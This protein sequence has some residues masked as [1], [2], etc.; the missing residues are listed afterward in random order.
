MRDMLTTHQRAVLFGF[1][2]IGCALGIQAQSGRRSSSKPTTTTPSV[3]GPK[4][5]EAKSQKP[6]RLQ[7]LLIVE[8]PNPFNQV[9]YYLSD[10][11]VDECARRLEQAA[12]VLATASR[13]H[14]NRAQAAKAAKVETERYVVWLQFGNDTGDA[15]RPIQN[16]ADE[17]YVSYVIYEPFT[18]N[19]KGTGRTYHGIVNVGNI[20]VSGPTSTR[21]SAV[22]AEETVKRSAR[23]AADRIL[24]SFGIKI[25]DQ[26]LPL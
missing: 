22:Y 3:D 1:V 9:P 18:A 25:D 19:I 14:M 7:F 17:L 21:R 23:E 16:G 20:G 2:V 11:V 13:E 15:G 26:R 6:P 12:H 24:N 4:K 10:T 5:V 8:D